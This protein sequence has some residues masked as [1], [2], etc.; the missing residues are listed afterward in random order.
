MVFDKSNKTPWGTRIPSFIT[1]GR[2]EFFSAISRVRYRPTLNVIA[3]IK[4]KLLCLSSKKR[5]NIFTMN[6]P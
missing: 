5:L 3:M 2:H 4:N 6:F 1:I